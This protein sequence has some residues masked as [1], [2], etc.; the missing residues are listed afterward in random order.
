MRA[1]MKKARD[2]F[3][4]NQFQSAADL[5]F[6]IDDQRELQERPDVLIRYQGRIVGV[7]VTF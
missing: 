1:V 3:L 5:K 2:K 6:E 7:E 4:L